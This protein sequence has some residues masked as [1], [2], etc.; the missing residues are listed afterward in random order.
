MP[1]S[2]SLPP[3]NGSSILSGTGFWIQSLMLEW[4]V[5]NVHYFDARVP[6]PIAIVLAALPFISLVL[7]AIVRVGLLSQHRISSTNKPATAND[8]MFSGSALEVASRSLFRV[9]TYEILHPILARIIPI[10]VVVAIPF[11]IYD[12][13]TEWRLLL[14]SACLLLIALQWIFFHGRLLITSNGITLSRR[15]IFGRVW[16][17]VLFTDC[18]EQGASDNELCAVPNASQDLSRAHSIL[19]NYSNLLWPSKV[20]EAVSWIRC[21][22]KKEI[23]E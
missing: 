10:T 17:E 6:A 8:S 19:I 18:D 9:T 7:D 12:S 16:Q 13:M 2:F 5:A 15:T 23:G 20:H 3:W 21:H 1:I 14:L 11:T 4:L 22:C